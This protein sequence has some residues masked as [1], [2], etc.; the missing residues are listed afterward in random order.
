MFQ[1]WT[2]GSSMPF[3]QMPNA[4]FINV[5]WQLFSFYSRTAMLGWEGPLP[6]T[7]IWFK[8]VSQRNYKHLSNL[9]NLRN[10][11]FK[12]FRRCIVVPYCDLSLGMSHCSSGCPEGSHPPGLPMCVVPLAHSPAAAAACSVTL[13]WMPLLC[14]CQAILSRGEI[15]KTSY[16]YF[17]PSIW[18]DLTRH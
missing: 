8:M 17:F 7:F 9:S 6:T 16:Y 5:S 4:S 18:W 10:T 3:K 2:Y 1:S 11:D 15:C 14:T 13:P 12:C